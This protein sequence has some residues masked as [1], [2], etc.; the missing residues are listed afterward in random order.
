MLEKEKRISPYKDWS[1]EQRI[2]RVLQDEEFR[3]HCRR[4]RQN[5]NFDK[6]MKMVEKIAKIDTSKIKTDNKKIFGVNLFSKKQVVADT[7]EF[8]KMIDELAPKGINLTDRVKANSKYFTTKVKGREDTRSSCAASKKP[9][10]SEFK[11]IFVNIEGNISDSKT[12]IHEFAHSCSESFIQNKPSKDKRM[13]EMPTGITDHL[14]IRFLKEKY[15]E[16][17]ENFVE[18]DV[19]GQRLNVKKAREC[20]MEGM[21]VKVMTGEEKFD[22]VMKKYG[23]LYEVEHRDV[24]P[25]CLERIETYN[26][27]ELFYEE[28]YLVPQAVGIEM[29]ERFKKNP[30][31]VA[32][33]LKQ[34]IAHENDWTEEQALNYLGL[35]Q[36]EQLM[37]NY[38]AKFDSRIDRLENERQRIKQEKSTELRK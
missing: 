29:R 12:C 21:I 2:A 33:Q 4:L 3:E 36:R 16:F 7:L 27:N 38:I 35:P 11:E 15:P 23:H 22:D 14:S 25:G 31:L 37:D 30:E 10:G 5:Q 19:F 32:K 8:Y 28:Q 34:I 1:I 13:V 17:R 20:L 6:T 9:D 18:D 24:L 26:F